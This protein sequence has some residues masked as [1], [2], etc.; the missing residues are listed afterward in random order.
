MQKA[1]N[2]ELPINVSVSPTISYSTF[3]VKRLVNIFKV[4]LC[5]NVVNR[6]NLKLVKKLSNV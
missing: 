5:Q 4:L 3:S 1:A 6:F 2:N